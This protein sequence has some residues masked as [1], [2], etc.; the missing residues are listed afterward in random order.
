M[1]VHTQML[2]SW[3]LSYTIHYT[4]THT[5]AQQCPDALLIVFLAHLVHF[6]AAALAL[7]FDFLIEFV[8]NR[9]VALWYL[10]FT[11]T[12]YISLFII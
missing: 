1:H 3:Y 10:F 7:D 12:I 11:I 2:S 6:A 5:H 9:D 8:T 4:Q